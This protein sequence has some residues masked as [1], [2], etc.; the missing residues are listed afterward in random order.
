MKKILTLMA[1]TAISG[2]VANAQTI[3][4]APEALMIPNQVLESSKGITTTPYT[5][6]GDTTGTNDSIPGIIYYGIDSGGGTLT[7]EDTFQFIG[8][9]SDLNDDG[10][11]GF[12][13]GYSLDGDDVV[14]D[15]SY[16]MIFYLNNS[17]IESTD[18]INTLLN[19]D[20]FEANFVDSGGVGLPFEDMLYRRSEL[21]NGQTYGWYTHCRPYPA[22]D[23][24]NYDDPN[25]LNNWYYTPVI[26]NAN[27]TGLHDLISNTHYT[28]LKI[29]P[30][31][32]IDKLSFQLTFDKMNK[33]TVVRVLDINGRNIFSHNLGSGNG[34]QDYS[35]D[36][37]S[38]APGNYQLQVITDHTISVEKFVKQ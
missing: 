23:D 18:S 37:Q 31:P 6:G 33:S 28:P 10:T 21:V 2:V 26:W 8:P 32:T 29:Y 1:A 14:A 25:K 11:M 13:I 38:L 27:V 34:T 7:A 19:I 15:T 4:L 12:N 24:A 17:W 16:G 3:D 20:Y 5:N 30:N 35:V 22:W 9:W 36:V